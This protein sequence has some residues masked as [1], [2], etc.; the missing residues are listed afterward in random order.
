MKW[1]A[2]RMLSQQSKSFGVYETALRM[3][4]AGADVIH[5]G[6]GRPNDDTPLPIKKA[7]K[8]A[9]DAGRVHY[10]DLQGMHALRAALAD[11]YRA[12]QGLPATPECVL[13]TAGV[14]QAAYAAFMAS[15]DPGDEVIVLEPYYPQHNSKIALAGGKVVTVPLRLENGLFR[16]DAAAIKAAVTSSTRM[17]VL[18][19]PANP[20]GTV[21]TRGEL[22]QLAAIAIENDLLVLSDEVYEY[23]VFDGRS[24]LSLASLPGMWERTITVSAFTKAYCM[25]GW[26]VGYAVAPA[27]LIRQLKLITMNDTTHPCVFAQEGAL[28]GVVSCADHLKSLLEGDRRRRDLVVSRLNAMPGISCPVPEGTI[29][30]FPDI[31]ALGMPSASLATLILEEAHV[32]VEAGT[33][34]GAAGEGHVRICVASEPYER[35]AEAMD[36]LDLFVRRH[37][38]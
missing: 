2:D 33:F 19:N 36:R 13:V 4:A 32:A 38:S 7:A 1:P 29:Y 24:H 16:L 6:V 15:L 18:I 28:A 11:R 5:L 12:E 9:L 30:A 8:A 25:D 3:Q 35:I 26:R 27:G 34:Y 20:T 10:G 21:F 14:T 17:I 37:D 31:R 23:I 22:E